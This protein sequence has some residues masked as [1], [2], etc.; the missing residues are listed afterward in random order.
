MLLAFMII[1]CLILSVTLNTFIK[2]VV[3]NNIVEHEETEDMPDGLV[4]TAL[5]V[6]IISNLIPFTLGAVIGLYAIL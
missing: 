1:G 3:Y 2:G 6:V 4:L 5:G